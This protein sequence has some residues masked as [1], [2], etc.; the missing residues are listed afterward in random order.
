LLL[1][2]VLLLLLPLVLLLPP[3]HSRPVINPRCHNRARQSPDSTAQYRRLTT[4]QMPVHSLIT[5]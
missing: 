4:A 5:T 3:E 2:L 1:S